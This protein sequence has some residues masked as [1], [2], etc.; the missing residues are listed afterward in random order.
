MEDSDCSVSTCNLI[1]QEDGIDFDADD[2]K[3]EDHQTIILLK[4][5]DLSE[6]EEYMEKLVF[7]ESSFESRSH[8]LLSCSDTYSS[9]V[10]ED[11]F[12]RA[13]STSVQWILKMR[14]YFGFSSKTAYLAVAYFDRSTVRQIV[15]KGKLWSIRLLSVACLSLAAKM[16]EYMVPALPEYQIEGYEF[17]SKAIQRMELLVLTTLEWRMGSVTPFDYLSYFTYK[18]R[19][20]YGANDLLHNA[21]RFIFLITEAF[22]VVDYRPSAIAAAAILAASSKRFT[23]E[24][25]ESKMSDLPLCGS[26]EKEHVYA[27]YSA[28]TMESH[29]KPNTTKRGASSDLSAD[30][31][32]IDDAVDLVDSAS[33]TGLSNKRKRLQLPSIR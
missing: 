10:A 5:I 32:S 1:C 7:R 4:E 22:T 19:Y 13:R 15:D 29:R 3:E 30:H 18:F 21:I 28:M 33:F 23:K 9:V 26:L 8:D 6:T 25:L 24:L 17:D 12:K 27:C 11:W 2:G 16:E 20:E 31:S 14:D